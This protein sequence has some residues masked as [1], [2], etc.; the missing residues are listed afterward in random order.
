M[1][2]GWAAPKLLYYEPVLQEH[3]HDSRLHRLGHM[4]TYEDNRRCHERNPAMAM[5]LKSSRNVAALQELL[6]R[7]ERWWVGRLLRRPH[8]GNLWNYPSAVIFYSSQATSRSIPFF[9][10]EFCYATSWF[11][12]F[13]VFLKLVKVLVTVSWN[14]VRSVFVRSPGYWYGGAGAAFKFYREPWFL[15]SYRQPYTIR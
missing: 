7:L 1:T 13:M 5:R 10:H 6:G 12:L 15:Y 11:S 2:A 4:K 3:N 14:R 9:L 8:F